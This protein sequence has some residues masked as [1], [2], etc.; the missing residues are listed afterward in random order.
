MAPPD[1]TYED[2]VSISGT[3]F[4][5][6]GRQLQK[7]NIPQT[8]IQ[9]HSVSFL[10]SWKP[11]SPRKYPPPEEED[12]LLLPTKNIHHFCTV[13]ADY[14]LP[15]E[16]RNVGRKYHT[17]NRFSGATKQPYRVKNTISYLRLKHMMSKGV[18]YWKGS[19]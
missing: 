1:A 16:F 19:N 4:D 17:P 12:E 7:P 6:E 14:Q 9:S 15:E 8:T 18:L 2:I 10:S 11:M 5:L 3:A 13:T